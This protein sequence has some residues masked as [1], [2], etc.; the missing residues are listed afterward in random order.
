VSK[1]R[2]ERKREERGNAFRT[3]CNFLEGQEQQWETE[4]RLGIGVSLLPA[5]FKEPKTRTTL[6]FEQSGNSLRASL[7]SPSAF[8]SNRVVQKDTL[9]ACAL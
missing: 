7:D 8:E 4:R 5:C 6:F 9:T 3:R 2:G 1:R